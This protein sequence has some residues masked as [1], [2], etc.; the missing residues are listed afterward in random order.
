MQFSPEDTS[1]SE[2]VLDAVSEIR[3]DPLVDCPPLYESVDPDALDSLFADRGSGTVT[4]QYADCIV[5]VE[6]NGRVSVEELG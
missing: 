3:D 4:F 6:A 2:A 5:T 1:A